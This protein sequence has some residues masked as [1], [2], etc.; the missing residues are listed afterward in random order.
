MSV[1]DFLIR[2]VMALLLGSLIGAERQWHHRLA[3]LKTN[4]LV[5]GGAML[6]VSAS[7]FFPEEVGGQRI[8]AQV[9]SGIGFLG[10]GLMFREG[11]TVKGL[12]TAATLW[13]AAAVGILTGAGALKEASIATLVIVIA[14]VVLRD[15]AI[16]M[17]LSMGYAENPDT[18]YVL[19]VRCH[20]EQTLGIRQSLAQ[21]AE[22]LQIRVHSL[23]Q[24]ED[25]GV[26]QL[27]AE[28]GAE[29]SNFQ[30][31]EKLAAALGKHGIEVSWK[32][33]TRAA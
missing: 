15:I 26:V 25:M 23:S 3:G 6:F 18:R 32:G 9:V 14:N 5:S 1:Q 22:K 7:F 29:H 13:C 27:E 30:V 2:S 12:N 11:I 28:L 20:P 17:D 4:A 33:I 31:V 21:Q 10:A 19:S 16:R 8:A 24:H